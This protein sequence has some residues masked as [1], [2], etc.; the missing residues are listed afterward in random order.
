MLLRHLY[1]QH[2]HNLAPHL[3]ETMLSTPSPFSWHAPPLPPQF[4]VP[5]YT[6]AVPR[7]QIWHRALW[8]AEGT[9]AL[10]SLLEPGFTDIFCACR[11]AVTEAGAASP[12]TL[13]PRPEHVKRAL[14][15][16]RTVQP[17]VAARLAWP[18]PAESLPT[19]QDARLVYE[20]VAEESVLQ[21]WADEVFQDLTGVHQDAE[22]LIRHIGRGFDAPSS[23]M[24]SVYYMATSETDVTLV[25]RGAHALFDS[26]G[27]MRCLDTVIAKL[28]DIVA[29][30]SVDQELNRPLDLSRRLVGSA[31]DYT[32]Q[33]SA[34]EGVNDNVMLQT[35][36]KTLAEVKV[37]RIFSDN[38]THGSC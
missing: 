11:V 32:T 16:L 22:A 27:L 38:V 9:Y 37:M 7:T 34:A 24:F 33:Y 15:Y 19:A 6:F 4:S 5:G 26:F 35:A 12:G 31:V 10:C 13:R 23:T 2:G 36:L 25:V 17:A 18:M 21:A 30:V 14:R 29:G 1:F 20:D 3:T 8:A 28:A